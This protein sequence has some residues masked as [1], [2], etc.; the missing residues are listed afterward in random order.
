[1][2]STPLLHILR[3]VPAA[4]VTGAGRGIGL[5]IARRL[6]DRGYVVNLTDV[7]AGAA[8]HA[9][10]RIGGDCWASELDVTDLDA[11][12]RTA[13]DAARRGSLGVWVNNAGIL[14]P[15]LAHDQAAEEQRAMLEVNAIGTFNGTTAALGPMR[16]TGSGHVINLISLAGLVAAPGEVA[17]A[18]SKHAALAFTLGTLY[19]LRRSGIAGIEVS[20]VCPDGVWSPMLHDKVD[21]P[22]AAASFSGVMLL[23]QEVADCVE[24]LLDRPRPLVSIPRWRGA[25]VRVYAAFPSLLL[26][27]LPFALKNARHRQAQLKR[28]IEAGAWPPRRN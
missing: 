27:L 5:E 20:A 6:A 4:V 12:R 15:G 28:K 19:D 14:L 9:A 1:L 2:G 16:E 25:L 24:C 26:R 3:P 13:R 18:A 7:D 23:P 8:A 17:Y 22:A 21:D 11:C 10:K